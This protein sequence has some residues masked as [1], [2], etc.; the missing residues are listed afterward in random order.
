MTASASFPTRVAFVVLATIAAL[1]L[2]A[3]VV[4][5]ALG[6]SGVQVDLAAAHAPSSFPHLLGT[7]AL[8]QDTLVRSLLAG[9]ISLLTGL[10]AAACASVVGVVVGSAAA[11]AGPRLDGAI[12]RVVDA[13]LAI[14]VLPLLLLASAVEL[15]RGVVP[16]STT[17]VLRVVGLLAA[18]SWMPVARL[19]RAQAGQALLLDHARASRA[20]G[21]GTLHLLVEHALPYC[22]PAVIV[23]T[24]LEV[25]TNLLAESA[26]SFLGLGVPSTTPTWGNMLT[27]ALDLLRTDARCVVV[28]AALLVATSA[29]VHHLGDALRARRPPGTRSPL[30]A[31]HDP[32][33]ELP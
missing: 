9:R 23:A 25:G 11:V 26:L 8:G 17:A 5:A 7:N 24:T 28:P 14:P 29:C 22:A 18:F 30:R 1:A 6:V 13:L 10:L 20:L 31:T 27:G 4:A 12:M 32:S 33:T 2:L 16:S 15:E 19:V 3:D 21:A